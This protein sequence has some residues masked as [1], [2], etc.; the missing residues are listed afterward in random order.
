MCSWNRS[1][2]GLYPVNQGHMTQLQLSVNKWFYNP[3][4]PPTPYFRPQH[5]TEY[6]RHS[7]L[8]N[9]KELHSIIKCLGLLKG[10]LLQGQHSY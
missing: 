3:H 10:V 5:V 6:I 1:S 8:F 2:G 9:E 4:P 7:Q